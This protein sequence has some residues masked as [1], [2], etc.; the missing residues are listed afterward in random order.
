MHAIVNTHT[1]VDAHLETF[2]DS[3]H[4][5]QRANVAAHA[6]AVA[7]I[8]E[9]VAVFAPN[10]AFQ[11]RHSHQ[12]KCRYTVYEVRAASDWD[13]RRRPWTAERALKDFDVLRLIACVVTD[14][15]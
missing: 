1:C 7:A 8:L 6:G 11:G 14:L 5:F 13:V 12:H 15:T 9:G 2:F 10:R 3:K 4:V